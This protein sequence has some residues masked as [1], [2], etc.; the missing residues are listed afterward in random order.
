MPL[1]NEEKLIVDGVLT[2]CYADFDH[3]LTHLTMTPMQSI[4]EALKWIFG[5][6]TGFSIYVNIARELGI[7]L[8]LSGHNY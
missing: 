8:L 7:I 6:D 1:V 3:D 2:S 5:D 4:A